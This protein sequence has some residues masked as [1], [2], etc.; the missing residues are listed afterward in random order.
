MG[1]RGPVAAGGTGLIQ[2]NL[3]MAQALGDESTTR[4][5]EGGS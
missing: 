4:D 3:V 2:V 5:N 1:K